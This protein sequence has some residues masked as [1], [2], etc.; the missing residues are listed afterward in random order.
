[1]S[2]DANA[3]CRMEAT[4]LSARIK[5]KELSA[6]EVT[7]AVLARM[8]KLEPHLHAFCTPTPEVARAAAL[9]VE[10]RIMAG[11][12]VG[13]LAGVP[14]GIKDLVCTKGIRTVSGS[15]LYEDFIPEEDD[16]VVERLKAA[17]AV[18]IG[19]TNVPEFGY[20]GVGHNPVFETTRNP[21]NLAMTPGGSSAGSGASVATG[22][23]PFAIGSDGGGSVRIPAAHS[24][25]FG[26]KASMGRVPLYPGCRDERYPGVSSWES[27]EHIGPMSRTVADSAAMLAVIASGPDPRD[28]HTLPGPEFDWNAVAKPRA[29]KGLRIAYSADWGYAA[30]DPEVRRVVGEAVKVFES[31]L[32]CIVEEAHPGWE[33]PGAAFWALVA[34]ESDLKG[35]RA[36][37][38]GREHEVSPHLVAMLE[39]PWTAEEFTDANIARKA[40]CNK[41]WRF[42][43]RYDLLL[44]PTLA[45]PPFPIHMQGPEKIEG[46]IVNPADWLCFTFPVNMTGQP[47]ASIPAGFTADGLPVGLQIIGRHLDDPLVLQASAAF[48]AAH[49]WKHVWPG[50]LAELGL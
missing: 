26:M 36:M 32:G 13:P 50:L 28:R 17:D 44:T 24:G 6:V 23:A 1:M 8:E 30:V 20:S 25:L 38:K 27:L 37:I 34:M 4:E 19:K 16:I 11:Q 40:L 22:V 43:Q 10:T 9:D 12:P 48:E 2:L 14:V 18:I 15:K 7:E 49:P 35:M 3:I 21:W 5:A 42:M 33:N 39:R 41:M 45:V 46:R 29:L 47:A 31:D